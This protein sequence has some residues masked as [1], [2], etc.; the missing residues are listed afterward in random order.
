MDPAPLQSL[1]ERISQLREQQ[2]KLAAE[3]EE[4]LQQ[5]AEMGAQQQQ[6]KSGFPDAFGESRQNRPR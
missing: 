4:L 6:L 2:V 5:M 3:Q 1:I